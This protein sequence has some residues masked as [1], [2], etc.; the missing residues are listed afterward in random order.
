MRKPAV[1]MFALAA[2]LVPAGQADAVRSL[3]GK[4][5]KRYAERAG[6]NRANRDRSIAG[7]DIARGFRFTSRKW[8][9]VWYAEKTDGSVCSAQLVT[10]YASL[11]SSKVIAYFRM[12]SCS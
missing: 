6:T 9:F 3:P 4:T 1:I 7:W 11:H 2:L 12:E 10:R 5:A 8:V